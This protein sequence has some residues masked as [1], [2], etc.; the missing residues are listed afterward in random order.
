MLKTQ[1]G[2]GQILLVEDD[3]DLAQLILAGFDEAGVAIEHCATRQQ[4]VDRCLLGPPDLIILD[5]TLPDGDGFSLVD[6]LRRQPALRTLNRGQQ[7]IQSLLHHTRDAGHFLLQSI[8]G[9][10]NNRRHT[11][12]RDQRLRP[13]GVSYEA[14]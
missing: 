5:L 9:E 3:E 11:Q 4:A 8:R 10:G 12:P 13:L 7:N 6:W 2:P 1:A 14:G